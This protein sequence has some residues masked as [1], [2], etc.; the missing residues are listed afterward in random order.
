[1][2]FAEHPLLAECRLY[3]DDFGP[4]FYISGVKD[5]IRVLEALLA[6]HK[7]LSAERT[8]LLHRL[9]LR[10]QLL[11][12]QQ[13]E[14]VNVM[15]EF[16]GPETLLHGD[17]WPINVLVEGESDAL[18]ARLIDWDHVGVGPISYDLSNFLGHFPVQDRQWI[19]EVYLETLDGLGW[20]CLPDTDWNLLFD[21]AEY[22]RLAKTVTWAAI[23]ALDGLADWAFDDL[24]A[25]DQWFEMVEPLLPSGCAGK[26]VHG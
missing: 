8:A 26:E 11:L 12:E 10:V 15:A 25:L 17:L 14:R 24:N 1:M 2:R 9:L 18:H 5:A 21:T 22:A 13:L 23:G 19:L 4:H 20:R 3:G 16:G 7:R 6:D